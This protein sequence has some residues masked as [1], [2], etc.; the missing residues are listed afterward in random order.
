M[1]AL[2]AKAD[3]P[4]IAEPVK[5]PLDRAERTAVQTLANVIGS[6]DLEF[7]FMPA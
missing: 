4:R 3:S 2:I 1:G 6:P 5:W 7:G